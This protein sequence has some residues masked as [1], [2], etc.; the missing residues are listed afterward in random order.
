M[1]RH[2]GQPAPPLNA[3]KMRP[4]AHKYPLMPG[5]K[6]HLAGGDCYQATH[7]PV[8]AWRQRPQPAALIPTAPP[9]D[10]A[11]PSDSG[12]APH[13]FDGATPAPRLG[14]SRW[15]CHPGPP[16]SIDPC[17]RS[18]EP[19]GLPVHP[20]KPHKSWEFRAGTSPRNS[21][22]HFQFRRPPS[23]WSSATDASSTA[24]PHVPAAWPHWSP[25]RVGSAHLWRC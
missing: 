12:A 3:L 4:T 22:R 13:H 17:A 2:D 24:A 18:C 20:L 7:S 14:L 21:S 1:P 15:D 11:L 6:A 16:Q 19:S 8:P 25:I 9:R 10:S 23:I 5:D